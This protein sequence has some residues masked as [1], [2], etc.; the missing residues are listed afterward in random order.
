[1]IGFLVRQRA[2]EPIAKG[3]RQKHVE[4]LHPKGTRV[5]TVAR[6][7]CVVNY[8]TKVLAESTAEKQSYI[9]LHGFSIVQQATRGGS[10]FE[11]IDAEILLVCLEEFL[12]VRLMR[13]KSAQS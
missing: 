6:P 12:L 2:D 13:L 1:M 10:R 11:Y 9:L 3:H 8:W 5:R 7:L 4:K